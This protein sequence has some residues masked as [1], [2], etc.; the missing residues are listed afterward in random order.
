MVPYVGRLL[1]ISL[2]NII[3]VIFSIL[4]FVLIEPFMQ[5]LFQ[6]NTEKLTPL[7]EWMMQFI[8]RW[9]DVQQLS[10]SFTGILFGIILLFL[11]KNIFF[12]LS[13]WLMAHIR[14]DVIRR[15]R[16]TIY[17]KILLLPLSFFNEQKKGDLMSRAIN[18]T[19]EVE[20]TILKSMQ[21][22][23]T[24]PFTL[25]LYVG[26]LF[27][28]D[29]QLTLFVLVLLPIAGLIISTVSRSLRGRSK[30]AKAELGTLLAHVE[31]SISGIRI[32]K[33]FNAQNISIN[34]FHLFN[35]SYANRQKRIYRIT[36][37][38]SPLSEVLGIAAVMIVLVFGGNMVLNEQTALTAGMFITYI[39]LFTQVINPAKEIS[40]AYS[41]YRRG[42]SALDRINEI[43]VAPEKIE[44]IHNA[45]SISR[46]NKEI[47]FKDVNFA[48]SENDV[49]K[50]LNFT[51][52]KG[53]MVA[54]VGLSGSG[55]S[56]IVDLLP[57]FYDVTSGSIT[58]D[59][60]DIRQLQIENLRSL[61]TIVSQEVV[62][63]HDTI[64]ENITFGLSHVDDSQVEEAARIAMAYDFIQELP[65]Q[66]QTVI[67]DRGVTLSGGQ[68]QRISIARAVLRNRPILILDEATSALDSESEKMVQQAI[69]NVMQNRTS[70]VIAHR[71]STIRHA[72]LILVLDK[73]NIVESGTHEQL[74]TL[75]G[76]YAHLKNFS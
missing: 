76:Q 70:L 18:D 35:H 6:Q 3:S 5:L 71:L 73:G 59:G 46:F 44:E 11:L 10:S 47:T 14:S 67:G 20:F 32:I 74:M 17:G 31:E 72:D 43:I 23:L 61:F 49:L 75:G 2:F 62:L 9:V 64:H 28:I 37:I 15:I 8:G 45:Q 22:F 66:F 38:A 16:E 52:E 40:T 55:K 12:T 27:Y 60:V 53:K 50:N 21:Q 68:R 34:T 36:D 54:L 4:T 33:A 51:I 30:I 1:I 13:L 69:D 56:T 7:A 48:Y 24:D 65:E 29:Y 42:L 57:R 41:N 63:F 26:M 39:A 58:I 19:Q 25:I